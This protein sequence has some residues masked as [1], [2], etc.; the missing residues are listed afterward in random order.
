MTEDQLTNFIREQVSAYK[1]VV[2]P[3]DQLA[4]KKF[5]RA[6][7]EYKGKIV[8]VRGKDVGASQGEFLRTLDKDWSTIKVRG[9]SPTSKVL[10]FG[11]TFLVI[12]EVGT[13]VIRA[14]VEHPQINIYEICGIISDTAAKKVEVLCETLKKP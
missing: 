13:M 11:E 12:G 14:G 6:Q 5:F 1:A 9:V 3:D 4:T 8:A 2:S 10:K 7:E